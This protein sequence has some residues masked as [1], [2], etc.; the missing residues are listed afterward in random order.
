MLLVLPHSHGPWGLVNHSS[1]TSPT[2]RTTLL[3][4]IKL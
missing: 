3:V 2:C 1:A 4:C